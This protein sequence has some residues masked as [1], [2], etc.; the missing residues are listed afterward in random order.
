M[1]ITGSI[2]HIWTAII[3]FKINGL[4]ACILSLLFP[5]LSEIYWMIRMFGEN[6]TYSYIVLIQLI[7]LL[8]VLFVINRIDS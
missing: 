4:F 6:N 8:I 3:A 5:F 1:I 7:L 2:T